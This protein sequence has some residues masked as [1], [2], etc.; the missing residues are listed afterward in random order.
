MRISS[1]SLSMAVLAVATLAASSARAQEA[2]RVELPGLAVFPESIAAD[3]AGNLYGSSMA[4]GGIWRIKPGTAKSEEWIKPGS[5]DSRS[6]LGVL[7]DEK[8]KLL[9]VCS[10]DVSFL[11]IAGPGAAKGSHLKGFDLASGEG[12]LSVALPGSPALCNDIAIGADGSVFVTNSLAPHILRLK[13]GG[14]A[15]EIWLENPQFAPPAQGAG[16]DGIAI[17]GDGNIYVNTFNKGELF[18]IE[19]KNGQAGAVTKL[20]TSRSLSFPDGLRILEGNTFLMAEGGGTIDL[21]TISGDT[22]EIKD[23]KTGLAGP[24]GVALVGGKIWVT[25]GQLPHL[26]D[27]AKNGPPKLPF[28]VTAVPF[29][30]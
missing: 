21:V 12:K 2:T 26:F 18:R 14:S 11:G 30:R 15:F 5:Y 3:A 28:H 4:S 13:P 19:Q 25:E 10:N 16:L 9:W 7:V 1:S 27:A 24:T 23:L 20:N 22:A 17:G 29:A 8:A 6:T